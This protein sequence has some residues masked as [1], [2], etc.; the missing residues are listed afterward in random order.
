MD[1][2]EHTTIPALAFFGELDKNIDPAQGAEAYEAALHTAGNPD[3]QVV[4]IPG[5]AHVFVDEPE[6]LAT[7]EAWIQHLSQ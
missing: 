6:Y 3:Y 5:V 1:I 4:S 2:I 7:L